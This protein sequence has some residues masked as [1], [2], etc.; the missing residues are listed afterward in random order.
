MS[1]QETKAFFLCGTTLLAAA[2]PLPLSHGVTPMKRPGLR[3][4]MSF[5]GVLGEDPQDQMP[6]PYTDRQLSARIAVLARSLQRK[7]FCFPV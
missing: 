5:G 6:L 2:K 7:I 4:R 3:R 1:R